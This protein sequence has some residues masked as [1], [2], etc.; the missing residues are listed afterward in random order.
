MGCCVE[1]VGTVA[2]PRHCEYSQSQVNIPSERTS[3]KTVHYYSQLSLPRQCTAFTS[4]WP[5]IQLSSMFI[6]EVQ[7]RGAYR[8]PRHLITT[9]NR[10][11]KEF[12]SRWS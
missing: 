11:L 8:L 5:L 12:P 1:Y 6:G 7:L 3:R 10:K 2:V 9:K 4:Q